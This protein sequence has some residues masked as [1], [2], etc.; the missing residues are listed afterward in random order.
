VAAQYPPTLY[1]ALRADSLSWREM[2]WRFEDED[3]VCGDYE[4]EGYADDYTDYA[5]YAKGREGGLGSGEGECGREQPL[6]APHS[7]FRAGVKKRGG[8]K[9][10]GQVGKWAGEG[11]GPASL[12]EKLR[13]FG[14]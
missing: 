4:E 3:E 10:S 9:V 5:D 6:L 13:F 12:V 8:V 2:M 1:F 11:A 7:R 14:C